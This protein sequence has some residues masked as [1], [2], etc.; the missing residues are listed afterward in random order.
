[1]SWKQMN[2]VELL[3]W[4]EGKTIVNNN[5]SYNDVPDWPEGSYLEGAILLSDGSVVCAESKWSGPYSEV[6]PD[7]DAKPPVFWVRGG[8]SE[9]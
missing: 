4:Y 7:I 8:A 6:T 3:Q 1:M 2:L 9:F 5:L